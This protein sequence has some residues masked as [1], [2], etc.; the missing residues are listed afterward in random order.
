MLLQRTS[1]SLI[2]HSSFPNSSTNVAIQMHRSPLQQ[3]KIAQLSMV[4]SRSTTPLLLHFMPPVIFLA[5]AAC[6]MSEFGQHPTSLAAPTVTQCSSSQTILSLE[7][8]AGK[9]G[10]SSCSSHFSIGARTICVCLSIGLF[11]VTNATQIQVCDSS[12]GLV[13]GNKCDPDRYVDCDARM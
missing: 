6:S 10:V 12:I 5:W 1:S 3:L 13:H 4:Q 8:R 9:S 7:W 11:M 2:F